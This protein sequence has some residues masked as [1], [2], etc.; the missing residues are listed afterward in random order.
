M[1]ENT[2]NISQWQSLINLPD[3]PL[4]SDQ[5]QYLIASSLGHAPAFNQVSTKSVQN[6]LRNPVKETRKPANKQ[7]DKG[8]NKASLADVW[9]PA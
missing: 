5:H 9:T 1:W 6:F 4:D 7:T 8:Q 2:L 3:L